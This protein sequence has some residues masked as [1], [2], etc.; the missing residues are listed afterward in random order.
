M[1]CRVAGRLTRPQARP[2]RTRGYG[3]RQPFDLRALCE[4]LASLFKASV[5]FKAQTFS[6]ALDPGLQVCARGDPYRLYQ[7]LCNIVGNAVKFTPPNGHIALRVMQSPSGPDFVVFEVEDTG[8][9]VRDDLLA[10]LFQPFH[11][12]DMSS[13]RVYGGTGLGLAVCK[14]LVALMGGSI[15][16]RRGALKGSIFVVD[17]PLKRCDAN[18]KQALCT[19]PV[20]V[21]SAAAAMASAKAAGPNTPRGGARHGD[22]AGADEENGPA[23]VAAAAAAAAAAS[24]TDDHSHIPVSEPDEPVLVGRAYDGT[25]SVA[26]DTMLSSS[27]ATGLRQRSSGGQSTPTVGPGGTLADIVPQRNGRP[28]HVLLVEDNA[29]NV[30][31]VEQQLAQLGVLVHNV[32]NGAE[33]LSLLKDGDLSLPPVDLVLMDINMPVMD[34]LTMLDNVRANPKLASL[35]IVVVSTE[36]SDKRIKELKEKGASFIR[37]PFA[38]EALVDAVISAIGGG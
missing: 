15:R 17:V 23:A 30:R 4:E 20:V 19:T 29:M 26:G 10:A 33:A 36:G 34:G 3:V 8:I 12:A 2:G 35:P 14:E 1:D 16:Y 13:I 25:W 11:Q 22:D 9:G 24:T 32:G 7:V 27:S 18:E 31:I 28:V 37:K 6:T 5:Q 38:P 21:A